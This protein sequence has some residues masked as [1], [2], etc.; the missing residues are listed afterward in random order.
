MH[1]VI[2]FAALH[3]IPLWILV[4]QS[5]WVSSSF[6]SDLPWLFYIIATL[7]GAAFSMASDAFRAKP[8]TQN[9]P[10]DSTIG[11]LPVCSVCRIYQFPRTFH[12]TICGCCTERQVGHISL[13]GACV[14]QRSMLFVFSGV[15]AS[16]LWHFFVICETVAAFFRTEAIVEYLCGRILLL[17]QIGPI[18]WA[19]IQLSIFSV[20]FAEIVVTNGMILESKRVFGFEVFVLQDRKRNPYDLGFSGNVAEFSQPVRGSIWPGLRPGEVTD[21]Y[22]EDMLK[23]RGIDLRPTIVVPQRDLNEGQNLEA[24]VS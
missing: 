17:V 8:L 5:T 20:Q 3:I 22:C 11:V 1:P 12:C 4:I 19:W 23:Y 7:A 13:T 2:P 16:W 14:S 24:V 6:H 18:V 15:W 21:A 9:P 10:P